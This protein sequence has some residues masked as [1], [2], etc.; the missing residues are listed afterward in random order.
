MEDDVDGVRA[1]LNRAEQ[2]NEEFGDLLKKL[3]YASSESKKLW[4]EIY[5]NAIDD[6]TNA[7]LLYADLYRC[8]TNNEK[9]HVDHGKLMT[10]YLER[11]GKAN[12][13]LLKLAE[14]IENAH[15]EDEKVDAGALYDEISK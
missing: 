8:V 13:Q 10:M 12:D 3:T 7:Y 9:G 14:I 6:R 5:E 15:T 4:K 1:T 2:K 11:M